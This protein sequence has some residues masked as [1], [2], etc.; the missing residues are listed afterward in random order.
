MM[1]VPTANASFSLAS[2]TP[3]NAPALFSPVRARWYATVSVSMDNAA[4]TNAQLKYLLSVALVKIQRD[5]FGINHSAMSPHKS[6]SLVTSERTRAFAVVH[7][8]GCDCATQA[9]AGVSRGAGG[10]GL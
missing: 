5:G 2:R 7:A 1:S 8:G 3:F 10:H 6:S 9:A 4:R